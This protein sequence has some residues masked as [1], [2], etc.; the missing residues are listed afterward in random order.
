MKIRV[1][2]VTACAGG[3]HL[4]VTAT[5]D[6]GPTRTLVTTKSEI[7]RAGATD[8]EAAKENILLLMRQEVLRAGVQNGTR[9]QMRAA[10]INKDYHV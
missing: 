4:T 5:I 6:D 7:A 2:N 9:A 10:V 1:T 3:E 8:V